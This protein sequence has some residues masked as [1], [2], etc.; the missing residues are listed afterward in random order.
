MKLAK[1]VGNIQS[2]VKNHCYAGYKIMIVQP[3][4]ENLEPE[5]DTFLSVDFAQAG[6]GDIVLVVIEG[7]ASRQLF[8]NDE[9]PVHSVIE[10]IVDHVDI[11]AGE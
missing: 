11:G 3:L 9:A 2:T 4:N 1:V 10:G 5:G 8:M 6:P 7:N